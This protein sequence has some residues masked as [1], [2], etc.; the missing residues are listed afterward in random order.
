MSIVTAYHRFIKNP[1]SEAYARLT[2]HSRRALLPR[3]HTVGD[4]AFWLAR[5]RYTGDPLGGAV[6]FYQHPEYVMHQL[7][8]S[9]FV[10]CDDFGLFAYAILKGG[11]F[12]P[13]LLCL[14]DRGI[15]WTHVVCVVVVDGQVW[16][17]DT[18]GLIPHVSEAAILYDFQALYPK[19]K[20]THTEVIPPPWGGRFRYQEA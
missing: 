9:V 13:R 12:D 17:L 20:Y 10:D 3:A 8:R 19:A 6:D 15:T 7:E 5:L 4:A 2:T 1:A 18:N 11:G 14:I 16:T